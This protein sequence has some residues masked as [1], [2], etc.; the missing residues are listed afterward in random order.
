MGAL[1]NPGHL[2]S[3]QTVGHIL[4]RHGIGPVSERSKTTTWKDFIRQH[5]NVPAGTD[6]F[7]VAVPTWRGLVTYSTCYFSFTW[8][9]EGSGGPAEETAQ[10]VPPRGLQARPEEKIWRMEGLCPG[11]LRW[12]SAAP[13][14]P[15]TETNRWRSPSSNPAPKIY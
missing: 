5:M 7:T 11:F 1:V 12:S 13:S 2:V 8:T 6:F 9:A 4:R 14:G 10:R 3:D 15:R